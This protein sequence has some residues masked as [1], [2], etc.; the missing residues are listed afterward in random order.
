MVGVVGRNVEP[1]TQQRQLV[2]VAERVGKKVAD[3]GGWCGARNHN[4]GQRKG[5]D[6]YS[7][8][9]HAELLK[10]AGA[11]AV[12]SNMNLPYG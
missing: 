9:F 10:A 3:A 11:V 8:Q 1:T 7:S 2:V 4:Y 12:I 5:R 6:K